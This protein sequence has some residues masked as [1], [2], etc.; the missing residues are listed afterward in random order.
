MSVEFLYCII[1]DLSPDEDS[2]QWNVSI[3]SVQ[4]YLLDKYLNLL[5]CLIL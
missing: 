5:D 4:K 2:S 3:L 1:L